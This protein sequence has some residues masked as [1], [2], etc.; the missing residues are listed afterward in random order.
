ME[1]ISIDVF[2][3][4]LPDNEKFAGSEFEKQLNE[5]LANRNNLWRKSSTIAEMLKVDHVKLNEYVKTRKDIV[6]KSSKE[7]GVFLYALASR[8]SKQQASP[9][10]KDRFIL[11][12]IY[13]VYTLLE[14]VLKEDAIP[15]ADASQET[16]N[17][18]LQSRKLIKKSLVSYS[19]DTNIKM[20][21][22]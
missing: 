18:L 15:M 10:E 8:V 21:K 3:K 4:D 2:Q 16:F 13:C 11:A 5:I 14:Q 12:K 19:S 22:L 17:M 9:T 20:E 6:L 1:K 7:D